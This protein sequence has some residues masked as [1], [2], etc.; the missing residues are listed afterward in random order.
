MISRSAEYA[1]RVVVSIASQPGVPLTTVHLA[2][3]TGVPPFY[4][5]KI[6]RTLVQAGLVSSR[7]GIN[8]GFRLARD[9]ASLT[10][11]EVVHAISALSRLNVGPGDAAG[12]VH[13]GLHRRLGE[14]HD[15]VEHALDSSTIAD[16][17]EEDGER[18]S[19]NCHS[20]NLLLSPAGHSSGQI[21]AVV[22]AI[23]HVGVLSELEPDGVGGVG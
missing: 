13:S 7:R 3:A 22:G 21:F 5:A 8:G 1:L 16:V 12:R 10:L 6:M 14:C 11:L 15:Y 18:A 9:P 20:I 17:L 19:P 2:E 4:L 23:G